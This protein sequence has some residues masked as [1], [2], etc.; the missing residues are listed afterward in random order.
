MRTTVGI[1]PLIGAIVVACA[2]AS[3]N[4]ATVVEGRLDVRGVGRAAGHQSTSFNVRIDPPPSK[5]R[6]VDATLTIGTTVVP[7]RAVVG[8][9]GWLRARATRLDLTA[10]LPDFGTARLDVVGPTGVIAAFPAAT[11]VA[12]LRAHRLECPTG[13]LPSTPT[14]TATPTIT[15]T[16]DPSQP[17][18]PDGVYDADVARTDVPLTI[19][20]ALASIQ[21]Q[22]SGQRSLWINFSPF[23]YTWL[24]GTADGSLSTLTGY[25][26]TGGDMLAIAAGATTF[27]Y[28]GTGW[29]LDG[30]ASDNFAGQHRTWTLTLRRPETGTP[31]DVSGTWL[32]TFDGHGFDSFSGE[33]SLTLTVAPSGSATVAATDLHAT[34]FPTFEFDA[35]GCAVAPGGAASCTLPSSTEDYEALHLHGAFDGAAGTGSGTFFIGSPP[36]VPYEGSWTAIK[37]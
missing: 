13:S 6:T 31:S 9:S 21:T 36:F 28:D 15:A 26:I 37:Q 2:A 27:V 25:S 14:P 20:P 29:R 1:R 4:A 19:A 12:K 16:P 17:P 34:G 11:C 22:Q 8:P 10:V 5:R 33:A 3:A 24:S 7:L 18:P 23:D 30:T 35:G 32:L